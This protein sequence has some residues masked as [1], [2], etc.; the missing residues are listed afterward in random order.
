MNCGQRREFRAGPGTRPGTRTQTALPSLPPTRRTLAV[1]GFSPSGAP[2]LNR[3]PL[4][5]QRSQCAP[6]S[7][8]HNGSG[9]PFVLHSKGRSE[10]HAFRRWGVRILWRRQ[11]GPRPRRHSRK[12]GALRW[13]ERPV[14]S[15]ASSQ[16]EPGL[17][18]PRL[19]ATTHVRHLVAAHRCRYGRPEG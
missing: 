2:D 6:E 4:D 17:P 3:R 11:I 16:T 10:L 19:L 12:Q 15:S 7:M 1:Q 9:T 8:R 13:N 18:S 14:A 5:P